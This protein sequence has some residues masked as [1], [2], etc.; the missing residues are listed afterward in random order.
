MTERAYI[1][2]EKKA[3]AID[4]IGEGCVDC[5]SVDRLEFDHLRDKLFNIASLLSGEYSWGKIVTEVKKCELRCRHCHALKTCKGRGFI[6]GNPHGNIS[7]YANLKCRCNECKAANTA[8][9]RLR[10]ATA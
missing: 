10:R 9:Y 1:R 3:K 5:G 2:A 7:T 8:Y 6:M 4:L